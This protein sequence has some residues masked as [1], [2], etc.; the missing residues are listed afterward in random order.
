M[1]VYTKFTFRSYA[2]KSVSSLNVNVG[3]DKRN[4][5]IEL[6]GEAMTAIC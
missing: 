1:N 6:R 2:Q 3:G 5:N 4:I